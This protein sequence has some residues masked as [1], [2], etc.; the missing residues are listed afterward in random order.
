M[1]ER[2]GKQKFLPYVRRPNPGSGIFLGYVR[3]TDGPS[4]RWVSTT[5]LRNNRV[6]ALADA[7][8]LMH[9][10]QQNKEDV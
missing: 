5:I 9:D 3:I 6:D 10:L 4:I 7:E 1:T 8:A 2:R